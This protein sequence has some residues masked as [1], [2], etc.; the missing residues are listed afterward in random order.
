VDKAVQGGGEIDF[1]RGGAHAKSGY[2]R[3]KVGI[4]WKTIGEG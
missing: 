1:G 4:V 2:R 3:C